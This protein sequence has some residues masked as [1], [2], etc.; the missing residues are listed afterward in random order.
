MGKTKNKKAA[1]RKSATIK[2]TKTPPKAT[3]TTK[4]KKPSKPTKETK[5]PTKAK[6]KKVKKRK[7][8]KK[9]KP[10]PK[11]ENKSKRYPD[12]RTLQTRDKF[13]PLDKR[14]KSTSPKDERRVVIIDS[15]RR[16]ELAVVRLTR[17]KQINTTSLPT[18]KKGNGKDSFFKHFVEIEDN[19]RN[20]IKVDGIKFKENNPSQDLSRKELEI[21]KDKVLNHSRQAGENKKNISALKSGNRER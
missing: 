7:I 8:A 9:A 1:S 2:K 10:S 13:L 4:T 20:P 11:E 3:K 5:S 17:Q 15:N 14:G 18:Y 19:E 12:G 21:V 6:P 16:D